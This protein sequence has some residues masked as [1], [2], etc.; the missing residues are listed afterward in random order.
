VERGE[1]ISVDISFRSAFDGALKV[2][3][4]EV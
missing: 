4:H 1:R 3:A 2:V